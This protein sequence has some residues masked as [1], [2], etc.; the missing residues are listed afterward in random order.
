M[1]SYRGGGKLEVPSGNRDIRV[2]V[3]AVFNECLDAFADYSVVA[4]Q[5]DGEWGSRCRAVGLEASFGFRA[6]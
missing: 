4:I 6:L 3:S 5:P 2:E 1:A